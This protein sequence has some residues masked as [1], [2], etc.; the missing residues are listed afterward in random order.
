MGYGDKNELTCKLNLQMDLD[1]I[2]A[3]R[4]FLTH[5]LDMLNELEARKMHEAEE[6][7]KLIKTRIPRKLKGKVTTIA[8]EEAE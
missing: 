8:D 3:N 2:P 6:L 1:E 5:M 7:K 4:M